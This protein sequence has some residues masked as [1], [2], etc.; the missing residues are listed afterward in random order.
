MKVVRW[1]SSFSPNVTLPLSQPGKEESGTIVIPNSIQLT[2][3][4]ERPWP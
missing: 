4:C 3:L 1:T 2:W